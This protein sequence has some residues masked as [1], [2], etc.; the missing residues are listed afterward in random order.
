MENYNNGRGIQKNLPWATKYVNVAQETELLR[1]L[2]GGKVL[3]R[4][5]PASLMLVY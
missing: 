3:T 5:I 4:K 1:L 2:P